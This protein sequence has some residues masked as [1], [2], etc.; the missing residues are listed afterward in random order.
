MTFHCTISKA[1]LDN[2]K[3][4]KGK[5]VATEHLNYSNFTFIRKIINILTFR[6]AD[7]MIVLTKY[8]KS[9]YSRF[10]KNVDVIPNAI[11]FNTNKISNCENKRI[12]AIGRLEYVKGFD[13]L[14]DI[15]N[16]VKSKH[17]DLILTIIGSGS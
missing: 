11:P 6:K 13:Y 12:I 2:K 3:Y 10:L 9:K 8:D 15:F 16:L 14:V 1:V 7:K 5:V 4:L 17:P